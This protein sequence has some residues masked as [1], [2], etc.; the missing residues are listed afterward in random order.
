MTPQGRPLVARSLQQLSGKEKNALRPKTVSLR[1]SPQTGVAIRYLCEP[2]A[3]ASRRDA[4]GNGL[5]R[6]FAPRNDRLIFTG[7]CMVFDAMNASFLHNGIYRCYN[8]KKR[9]EVRVYTY[10]TGV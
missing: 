9:G 4:R 5:P 2:L 10:L 6:R 1:T 3:R 7:S 8:L